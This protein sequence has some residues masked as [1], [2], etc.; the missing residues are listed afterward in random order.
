MTDAYRYGERGKWYTC[1]HCGD[2][3]TGADIYRHFIDGELSDNQC[4]DCADALRDN[5]AA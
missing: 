4:A 2:K 3:F 1:D 5:G